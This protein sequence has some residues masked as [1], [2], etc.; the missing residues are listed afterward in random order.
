MKKFCA[1]VLIWIHHSCFG[2]DLAKTLELSRSKD[3]GYQSSMLKF[4]AESVDKEIA[5]SKLLPSISSSISG[6]KSYSNDN[7]TFSV[8]NFRIS[9]EIPI[10][11]TKNINYYHK[12][13]LNS[14]M[15]ALNQKS[16]NTQHS[17][18]IATSYF[19][20]LNAQASYSA[21]LSAL[22]QY[23]K[24]HEEA[25]EMARAGLKTHV[26]TL[27]TLSA[28][29][30]AKVDVVTAKNNYNHTLKVLQGKVDSIIYE[31]SG[32]QEMTIPEFVLPS[33]QD[34]I[35]QG[36]QNSTRIK[37]SAL[38]LTQARQA[39]SSTYSQILPAVKLSVTH[40]RSLDDLK[41]NTFS[42][43]NGSTEARLSV[44]MNI[45]SGL[46]D[47][48]ENK[49]QRLN[50]HASENEFQDELYSIKLNIEEEYSRYDNAKQRAIAGLSAMKSSE[51][52]LNAINEKSLAGTA[53]EV[54]VMSAITQATKA[55]ENFYRA[56][57]DLIKAFLKLKAATGALN[58]KAIAEVNQ[59]LTAQVALS[60]VAGP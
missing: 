3:P 39:L 27:T 2:L 17:I 28:L 45:F 59:Y 49:K 52:S 7:D 24:S 16:F 22:I 11:N 4:K 6:V 37:K 8:G 36:L 56:N 21:K 20:A 60:V 13:K 5:I 1:L 19:D 54:E 44:T 50:Y 9:A 43:D 14:K 41:E 33:I 46:E 38:K 48:H 53:T 30:L 32:L 35:Q 12:Q 58:D 34:M 25:L 29:D 55:E 57:Y 40:T 31:L 10:Y 15:V 42:F 23:K 47:Y 26:D 51:A 18:D